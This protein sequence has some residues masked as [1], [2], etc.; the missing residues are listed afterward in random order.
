MRWFISPH[1][2]L[3]SLPKVQPNRLIYLSFQTSHNLLLSRLL[4]RNNR[5]YT[6]F[7]VTTLHTRV[8]EHKAVKVFKGVAYEGGRDE[9]F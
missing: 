1:H 4:M 3:K 6:R 9:D 2:R 5:V 8:K 7:I